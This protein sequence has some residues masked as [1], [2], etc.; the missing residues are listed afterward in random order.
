MFFWGSL[1]F[2]QITL[3][4]GLICTHYLGI[5]RL[6]PNVIYALGFSHLCN[7]LLVYLLNVTH[8]YL[9]PVVIAIVISEIM[10]LLY[11]YRNL[12]KRDLYELLGELRVFKEFY[13][14][15]RHKPFI[16]MCWLLSGIC[17]FT[18]LS[19]MYVQ[20]QQVFDFWD[21]IGS[22]NVWALDW[23]QN[24]KIPH[25]QAY[26]PQLLPM[27]WSL[28]YVLM[29]NREV[30]FF[31]KVITPLYPLYILLYFFDETLQKK[32]LASLFALL[33]AYIIIEHVLKRFAI[34]ALADLPV[35]FF[36]FIAIKPLW[37][38]TQKMEINI[39][40]LRRN[41]LISTLFCMAAISTKR[42][43]MFSLLPFITFSAVLI[44]RHNKLIRCN[45]MIIQL[46]IL[47]LLLGG[48]FILYL[49]LIEK[50]HNLLDMASFN[51]ENLMRYIWQKELIHCCDTQNPWPS[52]IE[53]LK[54][55]LSLFDNHLGSK[56][57]YIFL[58]TFL[59]VG[60]RLPNLILIV[61]HIIPLFLIWAIFFNYDQ[62]NLSSA[63]PLMAIIMGEGLQRIGACLGRHLQF[64]QP[65]LTLKSGNFALRLWHVPLLALALI[66]YNNSFVKRRMLQAEQ[67]RKNIHIGRTTHVNHMLKYYFA[68][69]DIKHQKILT[70]YFLLGY[71]PEFKDLIVHFKPDGDLKKLQAAIQKH[72]AGYIL[73]YPP[74]GGEDNAQ[75]EFKA[76]AQKLGYHQMFTT[77]KGITF[78]KIT[79]SL[80]TTPK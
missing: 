50:N 27:N 32:R 63:Y 25:T 71:I 48:S 77:S 55:S 30:Q 74:I 18:W 26:F 54:A 23:A 60:W 19:E 46:S 12:L 58:T 35:T 57:K 69:P 39:T 59:A 43:G 31:I 28:S 36:T 7:Y 13:A 79:P 67:K 80:L 11:I 68:R 37:D 29:G 49:H 34:F 22:W 2:L 44:K 3:L 62:R 52:I 65:I 64:L 40:Q 78:Y 9:R 56:F 41:L 45:R 42:A 6:V 75:Q 21:S 66:L 76:L 10:L 53:K 20:S 8:L 16:L 14:K 72:N 1:S 15:Y 4:P 33:F 38:M 17:L 73:T 24:G 61:T 51:R 70:P 5:K 47:L